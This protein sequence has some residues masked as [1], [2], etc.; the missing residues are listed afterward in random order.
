M[1]ARFALAAS[2][3]FAM[4]VSASAQRT[5]LTLG[6]VLEPPHLDPTAGAAAAIDEVV[7]ANVFEGLT[8]IASDGAVQPG[9]AE[10]WVIS[11]DGLTY[12]FELREGVTF[13]DGT[14][15]DAGD[16]VFSLDRARGEASVNAQKA[17]FEPIENV[18]QMDELTVEI[19]LSRPAGDFLYNMGWGDAVIVA[20][21]SAETNKENPVGTGPFRFAEWQKGA[22]VT[23]E[24]FDGYWG[25]APALE[26]VTIR[27]I[28]D[29]A[30]ATAALLAGDVQAFPNLPTPESIPQFEADPRFE[31][32]IGSTEGETILSTNNAKAPFD[33]IRVRQAIAHAIDRQAIIDGA[34]FGLG[35]P[36]GSHFAPHHPAYMELVETYPYNPE[37][38]RELLAEAGHG[39]GIS[40][41]LK[42]PPPSYA[43][44]GGEVI[45]A[46]LR[47]VGID[48]EII[49]VEWAQWLEQVFTNT[50]YD[51][52]IVSHT[53]PNDIG[54]YARED[55]YFNYDND[56]FD[57]VID[58]LSVT[59]GEDA[60]YELFRKAQQIIAED[61]VNGYLFQLPKNGVWD[62]RLEG[63]WEN[64]PVQ[65]NDVTGV[66][67]TQ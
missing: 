63:L 14:T 36:I 17:L 45:A 65:A 35:T 13:H 41:T 28:P 54:I 48:L 2:A 7:Y 9:L 47:E 55:Y 66:R 12:T 25:E 52:T 30:A 56:D 31:V 20:P 4:T 23:L 46:Q 11:D 21:E 67:W 32:V 59:A 49:P 51:L 6:M 26:Q 27:F 42:L 37:R 24:R 61:A 10:N 34:M 15:L 3:A 5:D 53:E 60:R 39:D 44:R 62:A 22:A 64:S 1:I 38:A 57:A 58:E 18:E 50:D 16:V 29:P 33:D 19:T 43:R 8:R 40:A